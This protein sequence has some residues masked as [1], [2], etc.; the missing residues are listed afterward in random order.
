[1]PPCP[2]RRRK[3]G[4]RT[5]SAETL[6]QFGPRP[7]T[8]ADCQPDPASAW[9]YMVRCADGSLYSGWT[10]DLARRLRAHKGGKTGA[11]YTHA[12][13]AVKLTYAERCTDKSA[14]LK[15]KPP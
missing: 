11:K 14:A 12:K 8:A 13:G 15:R 4:E 6:E 5:V 10:N 2:A 1:M 7:S 9:V 3:A